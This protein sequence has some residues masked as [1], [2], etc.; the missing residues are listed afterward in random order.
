MKLW[1]S[2]AVIVGVAIG[3]A[4]GIVGYTFVY[5]KGAAYLTNNPAACV[6]CH[7]MRE[8]YDGW[9]LSSHRAVA[10][11]NDCHAPHGLIGKYAVKA[12]NGFRHSLAF[13]TGRFHEPIQ[14]RARNQAVTEGACRS[15]H[16]E[17]VQA[18]DAHHAVPAQECIR[19]H[20]TV[21]HP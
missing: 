3:M 16:Q 18:I 21:G 2:G 1:R 17:I 20:R 7:I 9:I 11:C 19:C 13:T 5:A 15:C 14:I 10:V 6:N 8:Q 4:A 12:E